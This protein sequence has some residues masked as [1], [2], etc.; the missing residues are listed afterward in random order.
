ML[1]SRMCTTS[2]ILEGRLSYELLSDFQK[3]GFQ[4]DHVAS[5]EFAMKF[6]FRSHDR[7]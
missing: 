7:E 5:M 6:G 2:M 3:R 4:R 1:Q